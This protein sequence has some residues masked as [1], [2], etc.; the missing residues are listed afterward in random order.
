[1]WPE[2]ASAGGDFLPRKGHIAE[3][4]PEPALGLVD[5]DA[6]AGGVVLHLVE[7]EPADGEVARERV[8]EVD[9][10]HCGCRGHC[11]RLGQRDTGRLLGAEQGEE[12]ALLGVVG[13]GGVAERRADAAELL[14]SEL[15]ARELLLRLVPR[16]P[17]DLVQVFG[18][19][20]GEAI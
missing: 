7:P 14:R 13:A 6:L 12:L 9:A 10:A 15:L 3:V 20:L 19:R 2:S 16:T 11:E 1:M 5:R 18:E 8:S 4:R 17:N